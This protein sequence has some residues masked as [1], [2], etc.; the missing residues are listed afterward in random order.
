MSADKTPAPVRQPVPPE[1]I[2]QAQHGRVRR[3]VTKE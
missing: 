2:D 3:P 1:P